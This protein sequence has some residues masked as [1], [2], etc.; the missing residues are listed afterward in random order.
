MSTTKE[1]YPQIEWKSDLKRVSNRATSFYLGLVPVQRRSGTSI[2]GRSCISKAGLSHIRSMLY[3]AAMTAT[4]YNPHIQTLYL[5]L[6]ERG[7]SKRSALCAAMQKLVHLCFGVLK[8]RKPY[9]ADY[10]VCA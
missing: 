7:K 4:R 1:L 3:M 9:D 5:R 10:T 8:S 2:L 6:L